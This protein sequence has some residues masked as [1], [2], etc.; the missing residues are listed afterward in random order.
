MTPGI[1][2]YRLDDRLFFANADYVKGRVRE[3]LRA[4]PGRTHAVVLDAEGLTHVDATGIHALQEIS[5]SLEA[6]RI[7]FAV[8]RLKAPVQQRLTEADI[9]P[10]RFYPTVRAA[11][12]ACA[13]GGRARRRRADAP[14]SLIW[15]PRPPWRSAR[16]SS[17][18][19]LT[20]P[21][22]PAWRPAPRGRAHRRM[23][24]RALAGPRSWRRTMRC[25]RAPPA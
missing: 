22:R 11:V 16:P 17:E 3:A 6:D 4:A 8:A 5:T 7:A 25:R 14:G 20:H 18:Q 9:A 24:C 15:V 23:R 12:E 10:E 13:R 21:A 2:V 1:V 19:A